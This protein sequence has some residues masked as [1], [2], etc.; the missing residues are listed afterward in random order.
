MVLF[1]VGGP[2]KKS[3][4][5]SYQSGPLSFE[6]YIDEIKIITNCGFGCNISPKAELLSKLTSAQSTLTINDTSVTRFERNKLINSIF[7]NSIKNSFKVSDFE[8]SE[9]EN[10]VEAAASHNG[11]EKNFG[12]LYKRKISINKLTNNLSG[13]DEIIKKK[14]GKPINFDLRFHLYPGATAVKTMKGNSALIQLSKNKSLILTVK[15]QN[16]SLEKKYILGGNKIL[17]NTCITI[18]GNLVNKDK[19][20]H[21]EIKRNI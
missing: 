20:I 10:F 8:F 9:N 13:Y 7:G 19:A 15:D 14:D 16:I 5:K 11:Y 4:S 6:Y 2:P 21:W 3:F 18:S 1:D 12:C 17:D